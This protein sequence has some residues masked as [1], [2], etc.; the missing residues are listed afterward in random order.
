MSQRAKQQGESETWLCNLPL[1]PTARIAPGK[2][3]LLPSQLGLLVF[4]YTVRSFLK[5]GAAFYSCKW[6]KGYH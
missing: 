1:P 5:G 3:P 2:S 6:Y 4:L